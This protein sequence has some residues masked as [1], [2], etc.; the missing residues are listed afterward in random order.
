MGGQTGRAGCSRN[1]AGIHN[2]RGSSDSPRP[3]KTARNLCGPW[4]LPVASRRKA[5]TTRELL[6]P[7]EPALVPDGLLVLPMISP[8]RGVTKRVVSCR[9]AAYHLVACDWNRIDQLA[10]PMEGTCWDSSKRGCSRRP[11]ALTAV[12][13]HLA[14]TTACSWKLSTASPSAPTDQ[15][16]G[17]D[18]KRPSSAKNPPFRQGSC[19]CGTALAQ[20]AGPFPVRCPSGSDRGALPPHRSRRAGSQ[21]TRTI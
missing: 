4:P 6:G 5:P 3:L 18:R 10:G 7:L 14:E 12:L 20:A 16:P 15:P 11:A 17:A 8:P 19:A 2:Q 21:C 9:C 1:W 13:I